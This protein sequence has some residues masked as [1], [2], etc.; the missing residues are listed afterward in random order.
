MTRE[1]SVYLDLVRFCAAAV[2]FF[3]HLSG[4]R[5]TGGLFWQAGPFMGDAVTM[6]FV[7]SGFVIAATVDGREDATGPY[8]VARAARVYSVALPALLMTFALDAVGRTAQPDLYAASWGYVADGRLWQFLSGLLF[9]NQIWFSDVPQGSDLPYWSLGYEV[10]YYVIFGVATF[11]RGRG[12]W[13]AVAALLVAVGPCIAVMFPVWLFGVLGHRLGRRWQ[14]A[15]AAGPLLFAGATLAW[16]G[17]EAWL[18]GHTDSAPEIARSYAV[19]AL[20]ALHLL[21]FQAVSAR[22]RPIVDLLVR[23]VRWAAGATFTLYLLHLPVAQFLATQAPGPPASWA[24]RVFILGGT[25]AVVFAVA[26]FT[27][28]RKEPWRRGF[29]MLLRSCMPR[30]A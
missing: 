20:F 25:L 24:A 16:I 4:Q 7:L 9:V 18:T 2:V 8:A 12:R 28:R 11:V 27:E 21:G 15:A 1:T 17:L 14:P 26:E 23:P 6:F 19:G 29:A 22:F 10:W 5:F 3:G 30:P 13:L